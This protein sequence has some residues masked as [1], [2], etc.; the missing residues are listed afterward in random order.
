MKFTKDQLEDYLAYE[1][2]R[3]SGVYNM[4]EPAARVSTGLNKNEY[5]FVMHNYTELQEEV[6]KSQ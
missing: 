4:F 1:A 2:V 6:N 3:V 5:Y